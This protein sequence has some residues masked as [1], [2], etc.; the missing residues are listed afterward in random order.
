MSANKRNQLIQ[1]LRLRQEHIRK[2]LNLLKDFEKSIRTMCKIEKSKETSPDTTILPYQHRVAPHDPPVKTNNQNHGE[3]IIDLVEIFFFTI[4][5]RSNALPL[6][7]IPNWIN[8][9]PKMTER[10][11]INF[12]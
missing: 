6:W 2:M 8:K 10:N 5:W 4:M 1:L 11:R 12:I 7:H 9:Q 3:N